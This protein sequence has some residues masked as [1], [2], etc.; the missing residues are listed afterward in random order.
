MKVGF[1][2]LGIMGSPMARHLID[3]GHETFLM[4]RSG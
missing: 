3:G 4:S 1:I 2:G